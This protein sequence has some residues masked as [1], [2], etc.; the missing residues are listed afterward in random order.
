MKKRLSIIILTFAC[1]F[2][3]GSAFAGF[4]NPAVTDNAGY[5]TEAQRVNL[6]ARLDGIRNEYNVD[7]A[8]YI[9]DEMSG[10]DEQNTADDIFDYGSYGGGDGKDG[11][12]LY[13]SANPRK[14]HFT[15][16][17]EGITI[18]N[19]DGLDYLDGRVLPY[20]KEDDYENAFSEYADTAEEL[21]E[22]AA[23]GEPFVY[24]IEGSDYLIIAI[25][26]L[27]VSLLIALIATLIKQSRMKTAIR[28]SH[29]SNYTKPGSMNIDYSRDMFLYSNVVKTK[30]AEESSSSGGTHTSS[31]GETHGG[32]GGSY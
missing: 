21:L 28:Q 10:A 4:V 17:G 16:H 6:E 22:M 30:R 14:Y 25:A 5:L 26:L 9:E 23:N 12:L 11:I 15:T 2:L 24:K 7:V 29:A 32:R 20:L 8:V 13:L 31:S 27:L 18:F 19:D 1:M 3:S